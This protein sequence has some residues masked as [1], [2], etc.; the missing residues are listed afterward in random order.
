LL[1]GC[2][3]A[4]WAISFG[5]RAELCDGRRE[6]SGVRGKEYDSEV[7]AAQRTIVLSF[8]VGRSSCIFVAEIWDKADER[9]HLQI[10]N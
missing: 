10:Y 7:L 9:P 1:F 4:D 2:L 3:L 6:L 5:I 8:L